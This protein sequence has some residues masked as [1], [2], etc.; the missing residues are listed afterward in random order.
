M[1]W[2]FCPWQWMVSKP[3]QFGWGWV[4]FIHFFWILFN[5]AKPLGGSIVTNATAASCGGECL[6]DDSQSTRY[7][8]M[9]KLSWRRSR[10]SSSSRHE[11]ETAPCH[12]N[13]AYV[14]KVTACIYIWTIILCRYFHKCQHVALLFHTLLI[15]TVYIH[16]VYVE[17]NSKYDF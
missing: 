1:I 4:N 2:V 15:N 17:S 14:T 6:I 13:F 5:F 7:T 3:K 9:Y 16:T 12:T 8:V 10:V 11:L